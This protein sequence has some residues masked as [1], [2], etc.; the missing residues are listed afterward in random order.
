MIIPP[1][2]NQGDKVSVIATAKKLDKK[3]TLHGIEMLK[4]WGLQVIIGGHAFDSFHQFAGTDTHRAEDLQDALDNPEFKA[5]FI[6]RGG[7][8]TTRIIDDI[9]YDRLLDRPKWVCGFSDITA[10]HFQLFKLGIA[11]LHS[12]MP[13]FFHAVDETSIKFM[14]KSLFGGAD[15]ITVAPH[16]LNK[17]GEGNGRLIGGN[18]S[19]ICHLLGTA[20]GVDTAGTIL[21]IEDVDEQLYRI[22]RM[23][24]QLKR[25]GLLHNLAGLIVGQF[26]EIEEDKDGFGFDAMEIISSHIAEFDYPVAFNFPVGHTKENLSITV[27]G[28]GSLSVSEAIS[29][30]SC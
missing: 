24:L 10:L 25:A 12:P 1:Y 28:A 5:I 17:N 8:G 3:N 23:M 27:G 22:D 14:R 18:L 2:L 4:H 6:A 7:Y 30:L 19:I 16:P 29:E 13:S 15:K 21:F 26:S 9:N 20:T 11:S